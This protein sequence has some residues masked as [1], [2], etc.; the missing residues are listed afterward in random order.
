MKTYKGIELEGIGKESTMAH[1]RFF[2]EDQGMEEFEK[3]VNRPKAGLSA[4]QFKAISALN[5]VANANFQICNGGLRQLFENRFDQPRA[6]FNEEDVAHLGKDEQVAM[7]RELER[8]GREVF[9]ERELDSERFDRIIADYDAAYY[10]E[11]SCSWDW[12]EDEDWYEE[13]DGLVAPWDFDD[14]Y[15]KVNSFVERLIEAYAQYLNKQI[16]QEA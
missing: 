9:P 5:S 2:E 11:P 6:P 3:L 15:Y 10:E 14:R 8:F 12:D 1:S 16:D 7:L 13:D 4:E